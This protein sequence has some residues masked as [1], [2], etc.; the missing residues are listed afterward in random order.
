VVWFSTT[1]IFR[2]G[3]G[4][5]TLHVSS[6]S[7][8]LLKHRCLTGGLYTR[9]PPVSRFTTFL[10]LL[11][12]SV[13]LQHRGTHVK[14]HTTR[15]A[16]SFGQRRSGKPRGC[17]PNSPV[18]RLSWSPTKQHAMHA[19]AP[20]LLYCYS[21]ARFPLRSFGCALLRG[22]TYAMRRLSWSIPSPT[23]FS[24]AQRTPSVVSS[25]NAVYTPHTAVTS[26]RNPPARYRR[27]ASSCTS[28]T[29]TSLHPSTTMAP[30]HPTGSH[31]D[32]T[33]MTPSQLTSVLHTFT[34]S[35]NT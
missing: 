24:L 16:R 9:T 18:A 12:F 4:P 25:W 32:S 11:F 34:P 23:H 6:P 28:P 14:R 17:A 27:V 1:L 30:E 35:E 8:G 2:N 20:V 33:R 19:S 31:P 7:S 5:T 3:C 21:V 26:S 22:D 15:P 29:I 10:T 13:A